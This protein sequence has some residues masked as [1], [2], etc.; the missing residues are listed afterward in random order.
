MREKK[1]ITK[2]EVS[3]IICDLLERGKTLKE[4]AQSYGIT[5]QALHK[6]LKGLGVDL[7]ERTP[8][9]FARR[10]GIEELAFPNW[11]LEQKGKV[12][13]ND[14]AKKL[15]VS[16]TFLEKQI[17]RLGLNPAD[18]KRKPSQLVI[19]HCTWCNAPIAVKPSKLKK[20]KYFFC[21]R[22]H[23]GEWA[24]RNRKTRKAI[25]DTEIVDEFIKTNWQA[26]TD[27]EMAEQLG[28]SV[29]TVKKRRQKLGLKRK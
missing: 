15:R 3:Q 9:W 8:A 27:A 13:L 28:I 29:E 12:S 24:A 4:V 18:F 25:Y 14:L 20:Q 19:V 2:E 6:K 21:S 10:K 22:K 16:T 7:S 5:K 23:L 1:E 26:M 17:K 11:L